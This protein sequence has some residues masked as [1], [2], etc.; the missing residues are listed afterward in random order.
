MKNVLFTLWKNRESKLPISLTCTLCDH[1]AWVLARNL[2][3]VL[4]GAHLS[5]LVK[6]DCSI[7]S[8]LNVEVMS[9]LIASWD[10]TYN[11]KFSAPSTTGPILLRYLQLLLDWSSTTPSTSVLSLLCDVFADD[12][13]KAKI[14]QVVLF[15]LKQ[16]HA[17]AFSASQ[18]STLSKA[19]STLILG[20]WKKGSTVDTSKTFSDPVRAVFDSDMGGRLSVRAPNSLMYWTDTETQMLLDECFSYVETGM[21]DVTKVARVDIVSKP[22][23]LVFPSSFTLSPSDQHLT[24]QST[25]ETKEKTESK[26]DSVMTM[27]VNP[28][29]YHLNLTYHVT[30]QCSPFESFFLDPN[31]TQNG[32]FIKTVKSS[33]QSSACQWMTAFALEMQAHRLTLFLSCTDAFHFCDTL[34]TCL[35]SSPSHVASSRIPGARFPV[36]LHPSC[37]LQYTFIDAS[38]LIDCESSLLSVLL[39]THPLLLA[40]DPNLFASKPQQSHTSALHVSTRG[41]RAY[42]NT[43]K[44][45][46]AIQLGG[47]PLEFF[48]HFLNLRLA[49]F[50]SY[51]TKT[52]SPSRF[53]CFSR[54]LGFYLIFVVVFS[55]WL[56]IPCKIE[57]VMFSSLVFLSIWSGI[58]ANRCLHPSLLLSFSTRLLVKSLSKKFYP[59]S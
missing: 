57:S 35:H 54:A 11:F 30:F 21:T 45:Y 29:F 15:W 40:R 44:D 59:I 10:I 25:K 36:A 31:Y 4:A 26:E 47:L 12:E 55:T 22:E 17:G 13:T 34:A 20:H 7:A 49:F 27:V 38:D 9:I 19:R 42:A 56:V 5:Q 3:L 32:T 41:R 37:P 39:T 2:L 28:T 1:N 8:Q 58:S 14:F 51:S 24:S 16:I 46:L 53:V 48:S 33:F 6:S 50:D 43:L 23:A 52:D 18:E